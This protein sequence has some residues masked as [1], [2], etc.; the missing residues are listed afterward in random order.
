MSNK[1]KS[2]TSAAIEILNNA[3]IRNIM[4]TGNG[5]IIVTDC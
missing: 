4:I 2:D 5:L 1:L 3:R